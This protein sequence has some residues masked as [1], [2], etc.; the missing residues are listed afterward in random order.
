MNILGL[1]HGWHDSSAALLVD[2][3][4]TLLIET[5]R[6]S[7]VKQA[8]NADPS[9][10]IE[11]CLAQAGM[12]L[13]DIDVVAI[14]WDD[15]YLVATFSP[16]EAWEAWDGPPAI[17][18]LLPR[19]RF[20]RSREPEIVY[21]RHHEAHA[22]SGLFLS[23]YE[24][25]ATLVVDGRGECQGTS[26]FR[27]SLEGLEL[28]QEWPIADSLGNAYGHAADWVGF[29]F[30]GAG[31]LMGLAPYGRPSPNDLVEL[32]P[33]GYRFV[34]G[35]VEGRDGVSRQEREHIDL[36]NAWF[37]A[38]YPFAKGDA[39]DIM[40][41]AD[42]AATMQHVFEETM[43][44]LARLAK[45]R[46]GSDTLVIAGGAG[47][48]CSFNGRLAQSGLFDEVFVPPVTHDAGVGLGAALA[49]HRQRN[50]S[51]P[52]DPRLP[53]AY[54]GYEPTEKAIE[55][56]VLGSGFVSRKLDEPDL[57]EVVAERLSEG[58]V[59][60]WFQGRAE[61][62]Q[63]ALGA[64]SMLGDPR[65][66]K[67]LVRMNKVKGREVWRPLAPSVLEEHAS[68][69]FDGPRPPLADFMLAAMPVKPDARSRIPATVHVDGSAR[70]QFVSRT[71]NPRY[72]GLIDAFRRRTGV[73]VVMNTS[74]NL[75]GEPIVHSPSD[76]LR[77]FARS[78]MDLLVLGDHVVQ[79]PVR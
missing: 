44:H 29:G 56:A 79:K 62:G 74:F 30:W 34:G 72:W 19:D 12:T 13:D 68:E 28:L 24:R 67:N 7:R 36:M 25:S 37:R 65:D 73:P 42:L 5:D 32:L 52:V 54:W 47:L 77:S 64:R 46:V 78:E 2:G 55:G 50:P 76:A 40:A 33:D 4:L 69:F 23:G 45:E 9:V 18:R 17:R 63:R 41:H 1:N 48:N 16:A 60:G 21:V 43:F 35:K 71:T 61:I 59:V 58:A 10:A 8:M 57:L 31:K 66:R 20:P 26:L 38:R 39:D 27:G 53:H 75:A 15:P 6:V 11:A 49:V 22:A 51:R 14:G 3:R 70:P